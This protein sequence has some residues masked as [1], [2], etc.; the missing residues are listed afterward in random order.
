MKKYILVILIIFF[1]SS[2]SLHKHYVSLCQVEYVQ[3]KKA[4]QIIVS[5]FIDDLQN[6]ISEEKSID[7]EIDVQNKDIENILVS[8]LKKH[9]VFEVNTLSKHYTYIGKEF[10]DDKVLFYLEVDNIPQLYSIKITNTLLLKPFKSQ[11]NIVKIKI[12]NR[13][14]SF[15]LDKKKSVAFFKF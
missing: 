6:A 15:Y 12:G 2:F 5:I 8:Y 13:Y 10:V 7:F 11:K 3:S 14:K 9:L 1:S 4:L